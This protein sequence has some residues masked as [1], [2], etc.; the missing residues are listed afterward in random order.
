MPGPKRVGE[1]TAPPGYTDDEWRMLQR[2]CLQQLALRGVY[3]PAALPVDAV[4]SWFAEVD[5]DAVPRLLDELVDDAD[6]PMEDVGASNDA[7]WLTAPDGVEEYP[8]RD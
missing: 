6:C 4:R 8:A 1:R 2:D 7:V 5:R 3:R